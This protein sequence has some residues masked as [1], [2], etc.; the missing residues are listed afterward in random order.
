MA[1]V[2]GHHIPRRILKARHGDGILGA[3]IK[4]GV[5]DGIGVIGGGCG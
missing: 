1:T 4:T 2:N 3:I 5:G